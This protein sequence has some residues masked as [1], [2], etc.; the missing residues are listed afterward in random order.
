MFRVRSVRSLS[1]LVSRQAY[2]TST[3]C[4]KSIQIKQFE[5][6]I[7]SLQ[8]HID[9]MKDIIETKNSVIKTLEDSIKIKEGII[10]CRNTEIEVLELLFHASFNG[11][12]SRRF[13]GETFTQATP[14]TLEETF[15]EQMYSELPIEHQIGM[16]MIWRRYLRF[17][18]E[19]R[20]NLAELFTD[21]DV[22]DETILE[23]IKSLYDK[24]D[25]ASP[26]T[27]VKTSL[28]RKFAIP[29][30]SSVSEIEKDIFRLII[31]KIGI[32]KMDYEF[33][34]IST[35]TNWLNC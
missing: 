10:T 16:R 4:L 22:D 1:R 23:M 8:L 17:N 26:D 5:T 29:I 15:Q 13:I 28:E 2:S 14:L 9:S 33:V 35:G 18:P 3:E 30:P 31:K 27:I 12:V 20:A 11:L 19:F 6:K 34:R 24:L 32:S 7:H 21:T 25:E